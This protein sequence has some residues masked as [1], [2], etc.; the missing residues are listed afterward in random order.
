M[1]ACLL[2]CTTNPPEKGSTP[3]KEFALRVDP[4]SEGR[5]NNYDRVAY[6]ESVLL[7]LKVSEY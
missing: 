6:L 4:I 2:F 3:R 5:Q 1:T 7:P